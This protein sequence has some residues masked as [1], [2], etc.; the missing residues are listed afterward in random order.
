LSS[1]L[2]GG[3]IT[4]TRGDV[5]RFISSIQD[6]RRIA[7]STVLVDEAHVIALAE[8]KVIS[9]SDARK[10]L[11]A[12]KRL[13]KRIRFPEGLEDVHVLMEEYVTRETGSDT[14]GLLHIGKS[15]NDQVATAI[16]MTLREE[17]LN[18]SDCL[19]SLERV[20]L[21]LASKHLASLF[22]GYTHLQPAQPITFAH[23]LVSVGDSILRDNQ[24]IIQTFNRV[25]ESPMGGGALAGTSFKIDRRLVAKL[26][27]FQGLVE[28]SLD[29]VG[30][31]DFIL[32]ALSVLS[33]IATT[34]SRLAQDIIFYSCADV[35]LL[36]IP[37]EFTSTSSIMPQKK[38]PDPIELLRAKCARVV[39]NYFSAANAMHGL[40]SGYNLDFQEITPL[41]WESLDSLK[42][43]LR[44][45]IQ[46]MP[47]LK[48]DMAGIENRLELTTATEIANILVR[49]EGLSFRAAHK[50]V[51]KA[52]R[53]TLTKNVTLKDLTSKDWEAAIGK[54]M[55]DGTMISI[56]RALD[57]KRSIYAYRTI[58]S[59]NP[60]G[61]KQMIRR[62]MGL[63][64]FLSQN[65]RQAQGEITRSYNRLGAYHLRS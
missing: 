45:L 13:E 47:K 48:L 50:A 15:R 38:N 16:R 64:Q 37:D 20:I 46:L 54:R 35:A 7:H 9:R 51:G 33:M 57:P 52:V 1:I 23:Y 55:N 32:E 17:M 42:S 40:P 19:L 41:V 65:N 28:N 3:R 36:E 31:R 62:R 29:A 53:T 8:A 34:L 30:S 21:H 10:L 12:L 6:D 18:L 25:N 27:G 4:R 2:R 26:L 24:R 56:R 63:V 60:K 49:R 44:I 59:P 39:G 61:V 14:G 22:P 11:S 58:G 5:V 43:C